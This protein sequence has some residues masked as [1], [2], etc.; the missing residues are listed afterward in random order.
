MAIEPS[1][2]VTDD[3]GAM[4]TDGVDA[5]VDVPVPT[6]ASMDD[7]FPDAGE[8][9]RVFD[10]TNGDLAQIADR[11]QGIYRLTAHTRNELACEGGKSVLAEDTQSMF[12]VISRYG[13]AYLFPCTDLADCRATRGLFDAG[14]PLPATY[15]WFT[16][17]E[18]DR[19]ANESWWAGV[20]SGKQCVGGKVE[21]DALTQSS[22][23]TLSLTRTGTP[24]DPYPVDAS[25]KCTNASVGAA[26]QDN[27]CKAIEVRKLRFLAEL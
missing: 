10:G 11:M 2:A 6:D 9:G 26:A 16:S 24:A 18:T 19:L 4:P 3:A 17:A 13:F 22:D 7:A 25:G 5:T 8:H 27:E 20:P 14:G 23:G 12:V 21:I 15:Y 1:D